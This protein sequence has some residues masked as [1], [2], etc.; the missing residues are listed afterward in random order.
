MQKKRQGF[1]GIHRAVDLPT[2]RH[3]AY[4]AISDLEGL[5]YSPN[6]TRSPSTFLFRTMTSSIPIGFVLTSTRS[7][8]LDGAR[9]GATESTAALGYQGAVVGHGHGI[10][11]F[12]RR[13]SACPN[14]PFDSLADRTGVSA[15]LSLRYPDRL[16]IEFLTKDGRSV[17]S[18]GSQRFRATGHVPTP[19]A[20][21]ASIAMP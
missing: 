7:R 13:R 15:L 20:R 1:P 17:S 11:G 4:P 10:K 2:G 18:I 12:S 14:Y 6:R 21:R 8:R 16:T 3:V 9:F 5:L 19:S